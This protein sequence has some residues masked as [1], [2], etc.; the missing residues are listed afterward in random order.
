MRYRLT[1]STLTVLAAGFILLLPGAVQSQV[2]LDEEKREEVTLADGTHVILMARALS[3]GERVTSDYYYLPTPSMLRLASGPDGRPQFLLLKYNTESGDV[4]GGLLHFLMEWGLTRAQLDEA[5]KLLN[6]QDNCRECT[7]RVRGAARLENP[8]EGESFRIIS[9]TLSSEQFTRSLVSSG[10]APILP[11][12]RVAVAADLDKN[13]TQLLVAPFE[14]DMPIGDLSLELDFAY[15][16]RVPAAEGQII[17]DWSKLVEHYDTMQDSTA[18]GGKVTDAKWKCRKPLLPWTC[19]VEDAKHRYT[20]TELHEHLTNLVEAQVIVLQFNENVVDDQDRVSAVRDAFFDYFVSSFGNRVTGEDL[21]V[22]EPA[23]ADT[24][25]EINEP[26]YTFTRKD[27]STFNYART[28]TFRLDYGLAFRRPF[29]VVQNMKAWYGDVEENYPEALATVNLNDPFFDN[30]T[31][32][33]VLDFDAPRELFEPGDNRSS[34][35]NYVTVQLKKRRDAGN[36][37][38]DAVTIDAAYIEENGLVAEMTFAS[39]DDAGDHNYAYSTQWSYGGGN[40]YP[41]D[42]RW[43]TSTTAAVTLVPPVV[44]RDLEVE[45]DLREMEASDVSRVTVQILYKKFGQP[46]LENISVSPGQGE[47]L[48][49]RTIFTDRDQKGYVYRLVINSK[50]E[51]KLAGEWSAKVNDDYIFAAIPHELFEEPA[52]LEGAREAANDPVSRG[53]VAAQEEELDRF[54]SVLGSDEN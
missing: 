4:Q 51:G 19:G 6:D 44:A 43:E 48:V 9:A 22:G 26:Y 33:F 35:I 21:P 1:R 23:V 42:P 29:S 38:D 47:A 12:G 36:D 24:T 18:R 39:G 30:T 11:G 40:L 46:F 37:F 13:G 32:R 3:I 28:D 7:K 17:F 27:T 54:E 53:D 45:G 2:A 50:R 31:V 41:R 8:G 20:R 34:A 15:T 10:R 5:Q 49:R 25:V 16:A 14:R 52:R